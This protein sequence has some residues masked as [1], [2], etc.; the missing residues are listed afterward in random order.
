MFTRL[1]KKIRLLQ[2]RGKEPYLSLYKILGFYPNDLS[3]YEQAF[4]HKSSSIESGDGRYLN[5][6]R[7]EFLGDAILDAIIADI[8]YKHFQNKREGFL[9]NTRSKIVQRE[10]LNRIAVKLGLHKMIVYSA[11][12]NSHNNHLYGNALE[13]LIGAIYLDQGYR[14][15]FKFVENRIIDKYIDIDAIA[16]KEVNFKSSLIEWSQKNKLE[17]SFDLIESFMDNDG[18]PVFQTCVTLFEHQIGIG[19]GYSKKESQQNA[20]KMA[21]KKLRTDKEFQRI[22]SDLKKKQSGES[23][24]DHEFEELPEDINQ[25]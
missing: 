14:K 7:L 4:L 3:L 22:I 8:L 15:C 19:I 20:A 18:N 25:E 13:A 5:N 24:E 16:R 6:E 2:N 23:T 12:L 17:I 9:T 11:K 21:V 1:Y 10:Q